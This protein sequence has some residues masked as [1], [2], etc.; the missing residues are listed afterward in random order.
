MAAQVVQEDGSTP[1]S[2]CSHSECSG[3]CSHRKACIGSHHCAWAHTRTNTHTHTHTHTHIHTHTHT[4]F[5]TS[6]GKSQLLAYHCG[7]IC[8]KASIT[9]GAPCIVKAQL[10]PPIQCTGPTLKPQGT[11]TAV[12]CSRCGG[13]KENTFLNRTSNKQHQACLIFYVNNN[14]H[15]HKHDIIDVRCALYEIII[16]D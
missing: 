2:K 15:T 9:N 4:H 8:T 14:L 7:I 5:L 3:I 10:N 13:W 1:T 6:V 16:T 11:I 12:P